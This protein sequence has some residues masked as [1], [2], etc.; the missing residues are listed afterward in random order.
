M[1]CVSLS[2]QGEGE[3]ELALEGEEGMEEEEEA[4]DTPTTLEA[5]LSHLG[6][7]ELIEIFL[8]EQIDFDSLVSDY[9]EPACTWL[10]LCSLCSADDQ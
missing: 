7:A 1:L 2:S 9:S 4:T 5:A 10:S 8:K 6:L 3:G